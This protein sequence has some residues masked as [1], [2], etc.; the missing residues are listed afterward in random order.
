MRPLRVFGW[1]FV[2]VAMLVGCSKDELSAPSRRGFR[3]RVSA[4][5]LADGERVT[6]AVNYQRSAAPTI[7][8]LA[9][10][11]VSV[12]TAG[13]RDV[14]VTVDI[15]PCLS[16]E[17]RV[18]APLATCELVLDLKLVDAT[19]AVLDSVTTSGFA[20]HEGE[21]GQAPS[22]SLQAPAQLTIESGGDQYG[23]AGE[24]LLA[25]VIIQLKDRA[26]Q[27]IANRRVD[28]GAG[29]GGGAPAQPNPTTDANGRISLRYRLGPSIGSQSIRASVTGLPGVALTV[30]LTAILAQRPS[31]ALGQ[32]S[33]CA[34][35]GARTLCWG[36]NENGLLGNPGVLVDTALAVP[37]VGPAMVVMS[38]NAIGNGYYQSCGLDQA[39]AAYCWG[40]NLSGELGVAPNATCD[41]YGRSKPGHPCTNVPRVVPAPEP[42]RS[43]SSN[44]WDLANNSTSF[45]ACGVSASGALY[46]WGTGENG[47]LGLGTTVARVTVPTLVDSTHRW[48]AASVGWFDACALSV[49]GDA[50]CWGRNNEGEL[51]DGTQVSSSTPVRVAGG[52]KFVAVESGFGFAIGLTSTGDVYCWGGFRNSLSAC[53]TVGSL[54]PTRLSALPSLRQFSARVVHACGIAVTGELWCWGRNVGGQLGNGDTRTSWLITRV[55]SNATFVDVAVGVTHSCARA[56][57]GELYCW[58]TNASGELG[59]GVKQ[60]SGGV[61]TPARVNVNGVPSGPAFDMLPNASRLLPRQ[62]INTLARISPAVRIVD[63]AGWPV[64]GD[65]VLATVTAGGGGIVLGASTV[66]SISL[67]SA[68]DGSVSLPAGASWRFGAIPGVN[69]MRFSS[70]AAPQRNLTFSAPTSVAGIP[71]AI[72]SAGSGLQGFPIDGLL[73]GGASAGGVSSSI[74]VNVLDKD[75][76]SVAGASVTI[77]LTSSSGLQIVGPGSSTTDTEGV[78]SFV[79]RADSIIRGNTPADPTL[80]TLRLDSAYFRVAGT[81]V[82]GGPAL[83]RS[84][85]DAPQR[86]AFT[87]QP[88]SV[89]VGQ[90]IAPG[91]VVE[92]RDR[93][94]NLSPATIRLSLTPAPASLTGTLS[95]VAGA[96]T[97]D[98]LRVNSIGTF[99]LIAS[100]GSLSV[101]STPFSVVP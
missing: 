96:A 62:A 28:V 7:R 91:V 29:Q 15:A 41:G 32:A 98:D 48:L 56:V 78:A 52:H 19:G 43:L 76:L 10:D 84:G 89:R 71:A 46:C 82:I 16:D 13:P 55:E 38:S 66:T 23:W 26:G 39:G 2:G 6:I 24:Q 44:G 90:V 21:T 53:G 11:T 54:L 17:A 65:S 79:V 60:T 42:F 59:L 99:Q 35:D 87:R 63:A 31:I 73:I 33:N 49:E 93:Y 20:V 92:L 74:A 58:G 25:P 94:G 45:T 101:T 68:S 97:F 51:G 77:A 81:A 9:V 14:T 37:L 1:V 30:P 100:F 88:V 50:W 85:A 47:E 5:V 4:N 27:P 69:E 22:V 80:T 75:G 70:R 95:R 57:S 40:S 72:A 83:V 34:L 67:V 64:R 61:L 86:I 8:R 18:G 3:L 36:D 12:G